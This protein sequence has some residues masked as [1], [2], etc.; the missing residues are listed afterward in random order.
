M[1]FLARVVYAVNWYNVG[2]VLPLI[3]AGLHAG[4]AQL[5]LVLGAFLA[6]VGFFQLP[7]GV[8]SLRYGG[9]RVSLAG[10]TVLGITG[11]LS[12][13]SPNWMVLAGFRFIGGIGAAFFFAPALSLIASYFPPGRRGPVIGF[14][15]GGFSIGGAIGLVGGVLLGQAFGWPASLALAGAALLAATGIAWAVL[16]RE[17]SERVPRPLASLRR[18][19]LSI[20]WSRSLWALSLALTGFWAVIY[21][22]AQYFV[23]YG[24][25]VHP[26]WSPGTV[27]V[28]AALVVVV[29]FPGGPVGGWIAERGR[30]R[31]V[32]AGAFGAAA[33]LL[34]LAIPFVALG[35]LFIVLLLLGFVD[36]VVFAI[37][38]LIPSYLPETHGDGVALGVS[39]VNSI[40]VILGSGFAILFGFM[41]EWYGYTVAWES[42]ALLALLLLPLLALVS[43]NRAVRS[44]GPAIPGSG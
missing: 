44:L 22:V 24:H 39:L 1:L 25:D 6:G 38:Y 30:D 37:L 15:N 14:Y 28:L 11:I 31:R 36:G 8:A 32:L 42:A 26:E 19:S 21:I 43:P 5:G 20:L 16:P 35:P 41:V 9:R 18:A 13:L 29:S 23:Q 2:A 34:A 7:A 27:G 4:P 3:G 40:Q 33:A 12:A 17:E 10:L